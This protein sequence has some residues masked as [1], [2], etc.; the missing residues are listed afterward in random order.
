SPASASHPNG[1]PSTPE[2]SPQP[3]APAENAAQPLAQ[4]PAQPKSAAHPPAQH[5]PENEHV[6]ANASPQPPPGPAVAEAHLPNLGAPA[7]PIAIPSAPPPTVPRPKEIRLQ[8]F[9]PMDQ[10]LIDSGDVSP[11][12]FVQG[13]AGED[14]NYVAIIE[15]KG[16]TYVV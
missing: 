3:P 1:D 8:A 12:F 14:D 13:I 4:A 15:F 6:Q 5:P 16:R 2:P 10:R 7:L 11:S 9:R